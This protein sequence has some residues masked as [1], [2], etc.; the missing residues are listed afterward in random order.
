MTA[1]CGCAL[2]RSRTET[3]VLGYLFSFHGRANREEYWQI[4]S[5]MSVVQMMAI[6]FAVG[7]AWILCSL[8]DVSGLNTFGVF[9]LAVAVA[10]VPFGVIFVASGVRRAH[11]LGMSGWWAALYCLC[12]FGSL[13]LLVFGFGDKARMPLAVIGGVML[14]AALSIGGLFLFRAGSPEPNRYGDAVPSRVWPKSNVVPE[15]KPRSLD[16]ELKLARAEMDETKRR[17]S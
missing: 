12:L 5:G 8:L 14:L 13:P 3:W 11:D 16:E 4:H 7:V 6:A 9:A 17:L 15:A 1:A 2:F 10:L